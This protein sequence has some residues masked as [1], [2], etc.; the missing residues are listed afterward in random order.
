MDSLPNFTPRAQEVIKKSRTVAL[1]LNQSVVS[2]PHLL[3]SLVSQRGGILH[4][5][6]AVAGYDL[7]IFK[8]F[9]ESSLV[10]GS[11]HSKKVRFSKEFST[12][13][14]LAHGYAQRLSHAYVGTEHMFITIIK[15][16]SPSIQSIFRDGD[17][18]PQA[19]GKTLKA[20]LIEAGDVMATLRPQIII[21]P[22]QRASSRSSSAL[23]PF[24]INYNELALQGKLGTIV[25]DN[26]KVA[27]IT[28]ILCRKSKN[29]PI[30]LG[31]AGVGKTALIEG[32]AQQIASGTAP[33]FLTSHTI[34]SLDLASMIAGTKYRGQFEERL[35][36]VIDEI[37]KLK[38]VILFI[39]EI[40]TLVGAGS[41]EGTMDAANILKPTLARGEIRCIGATTMAEYKKNIEKDA[42][43][44]RRFQPV[45]LFEPTSE[46]A[47]AILKG[48]AP[49]YEEF[50]GVSYNKA[51]LQLC[52]DLSVRYIHDRYLPDKAIDI[53]D[54][55]GARAK[56][57]NTQ[58]P[59]EAVILEEK[60]EK[61]MS[62]EDGLK[63]PQAKARC[64]KQQEALFKTYQA[65]LQEWQKSVPAK[66]CSVTV[67]DIYQIV[68]SRIKVPISEVSG[69]GAK[70]LLS[71]E[72]KLCRSVIGQQRAV[73]SISQALMRNKSGLKPS[74]KPVAA[75]LFLGPSGVGKTYLTQTLAA[76]VF[77]K[78]NNL[79]TINMAE[80]SEQYTGSKLIGSAPGY[81]GYE[82]SGQL[83]EKVRKQPYSVLLFDEVEKA[84]PSVLQMLLQVL[85]EGKMT[86]NLGREI[87]FRNCIIVLTGNVGSAFARGKTAVGFSNDPR[88]DH[89]AI[90]AKV[91]DEAKKTFSPEF[92]N[93]LDEVIVFENFSKD[94]FIKI[95][96]LQLMTLKAHLKEQGIILQ[97]AASFVDF[98]CSHV[99]ELKD[100]ARPIARLL[101]QYLSDKLARKIL[102]QDIESGTTLGVSVSKQR[103]YIKKA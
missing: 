78:Q 49:G 82:A 21:A 47:Y 66:R 74:S 1:D 69:T 65:T 24:A 6:F 7:D 18:D 46:A 98:I 30:L 9:L 59:Q 19:I 89:A 35:K 42:A 32:L 17:V 34:Y 83:T 88:G 85:D 68:A 53:M 60:I 79:I 87:I 55:A 22:T 39:D 48:I 20:G 64:V 63:T 40:H 75:F 97:I 23:E 80:Y 25:S 76:E 93:R 57:Q 99:V 33:E 10:Q 14:E 44:D 26:S 70:K 28:E 90:E 50:H 71:L 12:V 91:L 81:V 77:G 13:L 84:H 38:N 37:K 3:F 52:V 41:A 62:K 86:D 8:A 61:L 36:N 51:T 100:G 29:N 94:D 31:E 102:S 54:Q 67:E 15:L 73:K 95:I 56:I 45:Q 11:S 27:E 43:L 16:N 5:V 2:L 58:R 72:S 103:V 4:E 96:Q 92:L 101:Q